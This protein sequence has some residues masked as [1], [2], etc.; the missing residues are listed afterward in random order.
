MEEKEKKELESNIARRTRLLGTDGGDKIHDEERVIKKGS[1][2]GNLW[3]QH[4]LAIILGAIFLVIAIVFIVQAVNKTHFDMQIMY[5]GPLYITHETH[6]EISPAFTD[7]SEDYTGN[8]KKEVNITSITYQNEEQRESEIAGTLYDQ[9]LTEQA[10]REALNAIERMF[11]SGEVAFYLMDE[12]L[13]NQ[14]TAKFVPVSEILGYELDTEL[15]CG[16]NGVYI[17]RTEFGTFFNL[18]DIPS[19]TVMCVML[20][21]VTVDD[22]LF[23]N[24][25]DY[26][27]RIVEFTAEE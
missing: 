17:K 7:I 1:F 21:T 18:R 22:E 19:D 15:M 5:T 10:S 14:H 23:E 8:G 2:F 4:K 6:G 3:Y 24:S 20:D 12:A 9:V 25:K 26:F 13:F 27:K 16:E 11:L